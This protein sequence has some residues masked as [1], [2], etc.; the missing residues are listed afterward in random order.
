[1]KK[2]C[3]LA[4]FVVA[5]LVLPV[6][7]EML[8][9][10]SFEDVDSNGS[11]GDGWT[12]YAAGGWPGFAQAGTP[13][14]AP[15]GAVDGT[16][17]FYAGG[18]GGGGGGVYQAVPLG[19]GNTYTVSC[20]GVSQP[21]WGLDTDI[22]TQFRAELHYWGDLSGDGVFDIDNPADHQVEVITLY[23]GAG[24]YPYSWADPDPLLPFTQFSAT[25]A[26]APLGTQYGQIDFT[27]YGGAGKAAGWGMD[28]ASLTPL[29]TKSATE[30]VPSHGATE[31]PKA[32]THLTWTNPTVAA[33][34]FKLEVQVGDPNWAAGGIYTTAS[35]I[36]TDS[37]PLTT[38]AALPAGL[39]LD[40]DTTYSW[41]VTSTSSATDWVGPNWTFDAESSLVVDSGPSSLTWL[42]P[43]LATVD[44]TGS[45]TVA[46][47]SGNSVTSILWTV[48]IIEDPENPGSYIED[49]PDGSTVVIT[50]PTSAVTTATMD[51][52]GIYYL[53]LAGEDNNGL[54]KIELL[55]ITVASDACA[56]AKEG[57]NPPMGYIAPIHDSNDDC[58]VNLTDFA[59][60]AAEWVDNKALTENY[61]YIW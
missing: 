30:P 9:N 33:S 51:T 16:T 22:Y 57:E 55:K 4:V 38:T 24:Y 40:Y 25:S 39:T 6:S 44:L 13:A 7:A 29:V 23:E 47:G 61:E 54:E 10:G 34:N 12:V 50:S 26:P 5:I 21:G 52:Q 37:D 1:M 3:L 17:H 14:H 18:S 27:Q 43:T 60:F 11:V 46:A 36:D 58:I 20:W 8:F 49:K 42:D 35:V 53:Q 28:V 59:A 45:V 32:L 31:V 41:R 48:A 19:A 2:K 56:A 15:I